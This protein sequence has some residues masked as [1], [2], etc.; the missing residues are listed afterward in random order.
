MD[1]GCALGRTTIELASHFEEV[2]GIDFSHAFVEAANNV[3]YEKYA[4]LVKKVRYLVGDAC[5]L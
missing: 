4:D 3:L 1:L 5:K 2:V